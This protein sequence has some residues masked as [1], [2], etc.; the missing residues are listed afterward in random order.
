MYIDQRLKTTDIILIAVLICIF[1]PIVS[2]DFGVSIK[3]WMPLCGLFLILTSK[4]IIFKHFE[5]PGIVALAFIAFAA[6]SVLVNIDAIGYN[7]FNFLIFGTFIIF[8]V[9]VSAGKTNLKIFRLFLRFYLSFTI[10]YVVLG[11]LHFFNGHTENNHVYYGLFV[12][13]NLPR[14][15]GLVGDPNIFSLYA[16]L[17][18]L[19]NYYLRN[20]RSSFIW[21]VLV[22]LAASRTG[23][24]FIAMSS[25]TFILFSAKIRPLT[26]ITISLFAILLF[27]AFGNELLIARVY[28]LESFGG[29][30]PIWNAVIKV[31]PE[32]AFFG[33]GVGSS[34][35]FVYQSIG[36][37]TFVHNT[38][39]E[40]F[41]ESGIFFG[42]LFFLMIIF[43][44]IRPNQFFPFGFRILIL[45]TFFVYGLS[46]SL[47]LNEV[48]WLVFFI[49][50][51][52]YVNV[53]SNQHNE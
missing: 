46:L 49:I 19:L 11:Y 24:I 16:S 27:I 21:L 3:A 13:Y 34:R 9:G 51:N 48:F 6:P 38:F 42:C 18:C 41:L 23:Y 33:Q 32:H 10:I 22:F 40:L 43:M 50:T 2:V 44:A 53:F 37:Y 20:F 30:I 4:K 45:A 26:K 17:L 25:V 14:A 47:L 12:Q 39:L 15:S 5:L 29:R 28:E 8:L 36:S 52:R 1:S 31:L 7:Q 35:D